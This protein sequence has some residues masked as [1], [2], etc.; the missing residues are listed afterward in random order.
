LQFRAGKIWVPFDDLSP[1]N[2]FGGKTNI[3]RI[4]F[5]T[6]VFLPDIWT[7]LGLGVKWVPLDLP[8]YRLETQAGVFNGFAAGGT[9]PY[10]TTHS[11][12]KFSDSSTSALDNNLDKAIALRVSNKLFGM[13]SVAGS[14]YTG[15]WND[16]IETTPERI[17]L[18]GIDS[19]LR[20]RGTELRGGWAVMK[21][22][23][24]QDTA[25]RGGAYGELSQGFDR[26]RKFMASIRAGTLQLDDRVLDITDQTLVGVSFIYAPK[27]VYLSLEYTRDLLVRENKPAYNLLIARIVLVY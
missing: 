24:E 15:R 19:Q 13:W 18:F 2:T 8:K 25:F 20:V 26:E 10:G 7:D 4:G 14:Y 9:D 16:Q 17:D 11:Y 22:G 23:L 6:S 12:P 5:G 1:H 3:S 27:P 21:V